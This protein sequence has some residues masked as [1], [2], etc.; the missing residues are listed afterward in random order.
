MIISF[1]LV[2]PKVPE[3]I[4]ASARAIKT[5]GFT[6]L[7]LVNPSNWKND[8]ARWVAHGSSDVLEK[9]LLFKS[10]E[11]SVGSSDFVIAMTFKS[12]RIMMS[13]FRTT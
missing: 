12:S 9:A 1:V 10:L 2:E 5:M 6:D 11:E 3:N 4:G 7:V 8:K 13:V